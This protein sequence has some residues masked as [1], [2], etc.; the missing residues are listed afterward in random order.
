MPIVFDSFE[1]GPSSNLITY[2]VDGG[3]TQSRTVSTPT[4]VIKTQ[5]GYRSGRGI[6]P[7]ELDPTVPSNYA[8]EV[9]LLAVYDEAHAEVYGHRGGVL[10]IHPRDY[11]VVDAGS[12]ST[13]AVGTFKGPGWTHQV[14]VSGFAQI[15]AWPNPDNLLGAM[16]SEVEQADLAAPL[17]RRSVPERPAFNLTRFIGELRDA[18]AMFRAAAYRPQNLREAGGSYLNFV[19]GIKPTVS[20]LQRMA[21]T[22]VRLD[23]YLKG[24]VREERVR[25]SRKS[26][27][28]LTTYQNSSRS[29]A[30]GNGAF[31]SSLVPTTDR[32][33]LGITV[34]EGGTGFGSS[35]TPYSNAVRDLDF[36]VS[37]T[38]TLRVFGTFQYFIPRPAGLMGRLKAA[39][40]G[41]QRALG[42]G[43]DAPTLWE[44]TPWT[45]L[46]DWFADVGGL[47]RYQQAVA[48][49]QMVALRQGSLLED[50]VTGLVSSGGYYSKAPGSAL[51]LSGGG[52]ATSV[53]YKRQ[54]R[55]SGSPYSMSLQTTFSSQQWA[56]LA[57]LGMA[58]SPGSLRS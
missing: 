25:I 6:A 8:N 57:A 7:V 44:L 27:R 50:T 4:R 56:I 47:L 2:Q 45:W 46:V 9:R 51:N 19:F 12:T 21:E 16:P 13:S 17:M 37:A 28:T 1:S 36:Y 11:T 38:R 20:D 10:G 40:R 52:Y 58:R 15:V 5:Y 31:F 29:T 53:E 41:A 42:G 24:Y 33:G 34:R 32:S 43:L 18:P 22:V 54:R 3:P 14:S 39:H 48:D 26:Q 30:S 55:R 35:G 23:P 49:N